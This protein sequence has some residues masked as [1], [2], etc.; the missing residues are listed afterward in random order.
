MTILC[1]LKVQHYAS[2]PQSPQFASKDRKAYWLGRMWANDGR[3]PSDSRFNSCCL[4][5]EHLL[6]RYPDSTVALVESPKNAIFG[7]LAFPQLLWVAAGSKSM[8]KR[9]VLK[10]LQ[11][12]D[13]MV[14]PD[15]DAIQDWKRDIGKM[16]DL[17]N[18]T[19]SDFCQRVAPPDK[20]KYDIA[21]HL[22]H[23][24]FSSITSQR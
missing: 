8:L 10:P 20:P 21:D 2:D 13:V 1:N 3:L 16:A 12:R 15:R 23:E 7:A 24:A 11:G 4:F 6:A 9:E 14:F 5:G 19:V 17:A 22:L 18:F